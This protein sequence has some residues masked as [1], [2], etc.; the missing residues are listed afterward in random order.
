MKEKQIS[1]TTAKLAKRKG[2][3]QNKDY[4]YK[5]NG[6][7]YYTNLEG[8]ISGME[9]TVNLVTQ[10]ILQTW[11]RKT[12]KIHLHVEYEFSGLDYYPVIK[13]EKTKI[14]MNYKYLP[15]M[16]RKNYESAL[17]IGLKEALKTL[18]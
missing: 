14:E 9:G 7:I 17:E 4:Y 12:H 2:F 8:G 3:R 6:S 1:F 13:L 11:L 18:P 16:W 15:K 5:K 10:S